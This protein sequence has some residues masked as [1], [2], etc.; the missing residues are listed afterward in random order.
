[1]A[2]IRVCGLA[3]IRFGGLD[4]LNVQAPQ[5]REDLIQVGRRNNVAGQGLVQIVIGKV[6]LLSGQAQEF[7]DLYRDVHTIPVGKP[8][9]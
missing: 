6:A 2:P 8:F 3:P 1:M 7:F 9:R 4:D 5:L